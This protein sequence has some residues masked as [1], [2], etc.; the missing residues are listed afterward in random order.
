MYNASLLLHLVQNEKVPFFCFPFSNF[1]SLNRG[2]VLYERG[3]YT[4]ALEHYSRAI[5]FKS[6]DWLYWKHRGNAYFYLEK[7]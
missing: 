6:T 7:V 5:E 4:E 3:R 2:N 1:V